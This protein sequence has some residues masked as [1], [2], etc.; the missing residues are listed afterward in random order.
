MPPNTGPIPRELLGP[1][2]CAGSLTAQDVRALL[3]SSKWQTLESS[4]SQVVFLCEF[5]E[6]G[7]IPALITG[8]IAKIFDIGSD[9]VWQIRSRARLKRQHSLPSAFALTVYIQFSLII[10]FL[11]IN[12][13][14]MCSTSMNHGDGHIRINS[15]KDRLM[16]RLMMT[17]IMREMA[18]DEE[19]FTQYFFSWVPCR[20]G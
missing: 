4:N 5:G 19:T 11:V 15:M 8:D 1:H 6:I 17:S 9:S 14:V 3:H 2:L 18:F 16:D 10:S 13:R 20:A 7:T 12:S